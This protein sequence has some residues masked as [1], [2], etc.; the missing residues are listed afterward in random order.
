MNT[1][2]QSSY[3]SPLMYL[4]FSKL[5]GAIIWFFIGRGGGG[6]AGGGGGMKIIMVLGFVFFRNW[7][8]SFLFLCSLI[9][10]IFPTSFM[11]F[12]VHWY[13]LRQNIY[14]WSLV[15]ENLLQLFQD[16]NVKMHVNGVCVCVCVCVS[17]CVIHVDPPWSS[18]R[19]PTMSAKISSKTYHFLAKFQNLPHLS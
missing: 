9:L 18:G 17:V 12:N 11:H 10:D 16:Y 14:D 19:L 15:N 2:F 5:K 3:Y 7:I 13:A 8:L 6:G 4:Q 1:T